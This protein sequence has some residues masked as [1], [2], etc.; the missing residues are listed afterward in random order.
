[1]IYP[2]TTFPGQ[3]VTICNRYI[4]KFRQ[5]HNAHPAGALLRQRRAAL[6]AILPEA[7][8]STPLRWLEATWGDVLTTV[9][10]GDRQRVTELLESAM[11]ARPAFASWRHV[12]FNPT[13][14]RLL[15]ERHAAKEECAADTWHGSPSI[16]Q[17]MANGLPSGNPSTNFSFIARL[18]A[19]NNGLSAEEK[20]AI[21]L[22]EAQAKAAAYSDKWWDSRGI[23]LDSV[24]MTSDTPEPPDP[25]ENLLTYA[26]VD[27]NGR[28]TTDGATV[29]ASGLRRNEDAY[30]YKDKGADHFGDFSIDHEFKLT[31]DGTGATGG[32][33]CLSNTVDDLNALIGGNCL[34]IY[35]NTIAGPINRMIFQQRE[36]GVSVG[37]DVFSGYT[38]NQ[39]YYLT[40][41]RNGTSATCGVYTDIEKTIVAD[42]LGFACNTTKYRYVFPAVSYNDGNATAISF[43]S[44]NFDLGEAMIFSNRGMTGG[45]QQL[46]GGMQ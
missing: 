28:L 41:S 3:K 15:K 27:P 45:M 22:A 29:T 39:Q 25:I 30:F 40:T 1:M 4:E 21:D 5:E 26:E 42:L 9:P 35:S 38:L 46:T 14:S 11:E 43:T 33:F 16:T 8:R 31:V 44:G 19:V 2:H 17:F 7:H 36:G 37:L 6:D 18:R 24:R 10:E 12:H 32:F 23:D 13:V 34:F 20:E